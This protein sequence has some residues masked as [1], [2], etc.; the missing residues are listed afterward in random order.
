[1][2]LSHWTL[3]HQIEL[4]VRKSPCTQEHRV[5]ICNRP[6]PS[7][8]GLKEVFLTSRFQVQ[9]A[10]NNAPFSTDTDMDE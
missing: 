3:V 7:E 4:K 6:C 8:V 5:G 2:V 10:F 9:P 1:M